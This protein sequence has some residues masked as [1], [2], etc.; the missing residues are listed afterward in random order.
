MNLNL[1]KLIK[2]FPFLC[3]FFFLN[4]HTI[5][6]QDEF[7]NFK[8]SLSPAQNDYPTVEQAFAINAF[9]KNNKE[10]QVLFQ[11]IPNTYIYAN[12][13][14]FK[15]NNS[16][17]K[18]SK[19][20][21][22]DGEMIDDD[23]YGRTKVFADNFEIIVPYQTAAQEK[24][25]FIIEYQGCLKGILCYPPKKVDFDLIALASSNA[26][27]SEKDS[28]KPLH[29]L[30]NSETSSVPS[31]TISSI[32][33]KNKATDL[34]HH[35]K[36]WQ[37]II[38]FI[39]FG[40]LLSLT[41]C[42]LPMV[43]IISGIIAGHKHKITKKQAFVLSF[44]YVL[45]M[46]L[47]YMVAGILV[48][49][50]GLNLIS[51]L[52]HPAVI[53]V[54]SILFIILAIASFE[55]VELKSPNF[56]AHRLTA[57]ERKQK[58]GTYFGVAMM[59]V[60]SAL[61][62]SPCAT[63]PLAGALMYIST[64][65]NILLGGVALF[66]M[67][68]AMGTPV[69]LFGTSAGHWLPKAGPWMREINIFFGVVFLALAIYLLTRLIPGPLALTLWSLLLIFYAVHLGLLEPAKHEWQKFIKAF[70]L[71][72]T[73]YGSLLLVGATLNNSDLFHP[74][75]YNLNRGNCMSND[76][77]NQLNFTEVKSMP[78]LTK[79]LIDAKANQQF[80]VLTFSAKWC[81][82]CRYLEQ[83]VFNDPKIKNILASFKRLEVDITDYTDE[84]KKLMSDLV[85][86]N[87]PTVIFYDKSGNELTSKRVTSEVSPEDFYELL[88]SL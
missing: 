84:D 1:K 67:G 13:L 58:G 62:M 88:T 87:P 34:L 28:V 48:A 36:V 73:I 43:P 82:S 70:A 39:I 64:T 35:A 63:A 16:N 11:A 69:L 17:I 50:A 2:T 71:V 59:G 56:I 65:G 10:I 80:T 31:K 77:T 33:S 86:F 66:C 85:V 53:I 25:N 46:S 32:D 26:S 14:K 12:S 9:V 79:N 8:S 83:K 42:V 30:Q 40:L 20:Q 55:L 23:H 72:M 68:F 21:L 44:V 47:T 24:F 6:A 61:I 76:K 3:L 27:N 37:I 52:Q 54:T 45:S 78:D 75:G 18:L 60:I 81:V 19:E 49:A 22:P 29:V 38:G 51:N 57:T 15:V 7:A 4:I 74:L 41:P 5:N